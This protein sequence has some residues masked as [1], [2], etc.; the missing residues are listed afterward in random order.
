VKNKKLASSFLVLALCFA[1]EIKAVGF[2]Q[3]KNKEKKEPIWKSVVISKEKGELTIIRQLGPENWDDFLVEPKIYINLG[4]D[5]L[6]IMPSTT[7]TI[8]SPRVKTENG[9]SA[10]IVQGNRENV[11]SIRVIPSIIYGKGIDLKID[12]K[13]EPEM[14][15]SRQEKVFLQNGDSAVLELFEN[16]ARQSKIAVKLTPFVEV[17]APAKEFPRKISEIQL[18]DSFLT[19]N[20][21]KLIAKGSLNAVSDADDIF[22]FFSCEERGL[23]LLFFRPTEGAKPM[24]AVNGKVLKIKIGEDTF[25]WESRDPILPEGKW[26]VWVKNIPKLSQINV[27]GNA[28]IGKNGLIGIGVGKEAWKRLFQ[29]APRFD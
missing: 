10:E 9:K 22:L 14:K 17:I 8:A 4:I 29:S 2:F 7:T 15:E 16:K 27:S 1:L 12:F 20:E 18:K 24:G 13:K 3:D 19:L 28:I 11:L 5:L 26:L 23:F 6:E 21:D 25:E